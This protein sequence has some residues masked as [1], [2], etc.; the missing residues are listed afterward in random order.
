MVAR[1]RAPRTSSGDVRRRL[2]LPYCGMRHAPRARRTRLPAAP[3]SRRARCRRRGY[4]ATAPEGDRGHRQLVLFRT[5]ARGLHGSP[6]TR[7]A[8]T[9]LPR[10]A[11]TR[12]CGISATAE[13]PTCPC[14]RSRTTP[15][16]PG[17]SARFAIPLCRSARNG[18]SASTRTDGCSSCL[19]RSAV[20]WRL[21]HPVGDTPMLRGSDAG[22]TTLFPFVVPARRR[23]ARYVN[24]HPARGAPRTLRERRDV[25]VAAGELD[26]SG[27]WRC[28]DSR[29]DRDV[30]GTS[31]ACSVRS[32][33]SPSRS[34]CVKGGCA[35]NVPRAA[36][37]IGFP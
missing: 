5:H 12:C 3:F 4:R 32:W 6:S 2:T 11:T 29:T 28:A 35:F 20:A 21:T 31:G 14:W 25:R 22:S 26:S 1:R 17:K 24:C 23:V 15:I 30:S 7:F 18:C 9:S 36:S 10:S 27:R 16:V 8:G 19:V 33:R 13:M 37:A 34:P